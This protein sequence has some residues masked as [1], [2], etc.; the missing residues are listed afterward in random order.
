MALHTSFSGNCF[1]TSA[2]VPPLT[3]VENCSSS[4]H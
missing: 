1:A 2:E 4:H 3:L